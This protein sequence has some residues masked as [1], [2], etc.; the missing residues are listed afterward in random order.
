MSG[1]HTTLVNVTRAIEVMRFDYKTL[2]EEHHTCGLTVHMLDEG[3]SDM[4]RHDA[5]T[6]QLKNDEIL[7]MLQKLAAALQL[8]N[9]DISDMHPHHAATLQLKNNEISDMHQQHAEALQMK[10]DEYVKMLQHHA[11]NL[12]M[13]KGLEEYQSCNNNQFNYFQWSEIVLLTKVRKLGQVLRP[14]V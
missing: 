3:I 14:L 9:I 12:D 4:Q 10:E 11:D 13:I 5:A 6:L 1:L 7:D 2:V 8:K